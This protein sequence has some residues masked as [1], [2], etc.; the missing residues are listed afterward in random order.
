[1]TIKM[2]IVDDH[3]LFRQGLVS[4][5]NHQPDFEVIGEA[6]N[7]NEAIEAAERLKPNLILMD[8][9][10]P[11]GTGV[12]AT[13]TIL[14]T[15]PN[16]NIVFL[17][18]HEDDERL[19]S[20][21]RSGAKGYLLK[22]LPVAKLLASLR[23]LEHGQAPISRE[24]TG[25]II[26]A[27]ARSEPNK[28]VDKPNLIE[29]LTSREIDVFYELTTGASN[30]EIADRLFISENT[31]KNHVHNILEKLEMSNRREVASYA[32]RYGITKPNG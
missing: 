21:I 32:I 15:Q 5:F 25:R 30:Q 19:F 6:G 18:M 7:V 27:F 11:D 4:L 17:T 16:T 13:Q 9:S 10:L 12:E 1:M 14:R 20:A 29:L 28:V 22:N 24:M 31:V 8:F 3:V 26:D 2:L 23:A